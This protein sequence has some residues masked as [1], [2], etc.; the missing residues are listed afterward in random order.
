MRRE[1]P[2]ITVEQLQEFHV[3]LDVLTAALGDDDAEATWWLIM[4]AVE[5]KS[6]QGIKEHLAVLL[7]IAAQRIKELQSTPAVMASAP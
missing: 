3:E 6:R 5:T 4:D 7:V 2:V 1:L